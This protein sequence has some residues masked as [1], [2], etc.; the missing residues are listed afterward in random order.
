[1]KLKTKA[2]CPAGISSFFQICDSDERGSPLTDPKRIGSRGGGFAIKKGVLT[3]VEVEESEKKEIQIF[4]NND[5]APQAKT[6]K[7]VVEKLLKIADKPCR[8]K[9]KHIVE[10]PIGAGFGTSAAGA[11]SVAMALARALN[12]SLTLN[13]I[14][15]IAHLAEIKCKTG[16]GTVSGLLYGGCVL[17]KEPGAPSSS[18]IDRIPVPPNYYLVVGVFQ[19]R[20]TDEYLKKIDRSLINRIGKETLKKILKK[21][22]LSNFMKMSRRFAEE[23]GLATERVIKLMDAAEYAGAVGA[24]QNMLG[25]AVHALV[26]NEKLN[27]LLRAFKERLPRERIII[28]RI[29]SGGVRLV[30]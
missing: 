21:P 23:T 1:M 18:L 8:V 29:E 15:R 19:P 28:S 22:S 11:L 14:G 3:E 16:L 24:A 25:E 7:K 4:I 13:E 17:V 27:C 9:V 6:T 26:S 2:F 5:P 20:M 12:L 10:V 30:R